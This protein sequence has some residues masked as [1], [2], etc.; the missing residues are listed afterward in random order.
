VLQ[1][2]KRKVE[3]KMTARNGSADWRGDIKK[4]S[5]TVTVGNGVFQG[6]SIKLVQRIR[7]HGGKPATPL[8][9]GLPIKEKT[10][11]GS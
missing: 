6:A 3:A 5:G 4:G 9:A 8:Y 7:P 10:D 1:E 2:Q 11:T